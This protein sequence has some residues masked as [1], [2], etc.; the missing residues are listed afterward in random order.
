MNAP[1]ATKSERAMF[2]NLIS[3]MS[4]QIISYSKV[5]VNIWK[6]GREKSRKLN[7]SKGQFKMYCK[8]NIMPSMVQ[9]IIPD[10]VAYWTEFKF[11]QHVYLEDMVA[12]DRT[13]NMI[14]CFY[15]LFVFF[16]FSSYEMHFFFRKT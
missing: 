13:L 14:K 3:I 2:N 1:T 15:S 8:R 6:Y 12:R 9:N 16:C 11:L 4:R 5:Q 7:F 10:K